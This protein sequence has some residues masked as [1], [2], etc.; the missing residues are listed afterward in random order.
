MVRSF[1]V[2][3]MALVAIS[4]EA[5]KAPVNERP[6]GEDI[7]IR[8]WDNA[9]APHSNNLTCEV[10]EPQPNRLTFNSTMELLV[11]V[12]D[13]EK[14]A[15]REQ[16]VVICPGGGYQMLSMDY[17]GAI[18]AQWFADNGITAAVLKYRMP[19]GVEQV[20]FEDAEK[21][22]DIMRERAAEWGYKADQ[23]GIVGSSAGGHLAAATSTLAPMA[24]RP[25]FTILFYPVITSEV[26]KGHQGSFNNLLGVERSSAESEFYS[27]DRRVSQ[28]TP[29]A[30]IF[31]SSNDNVVPSISSTRYFDALQRYNIPVSLYLFPTGGHGWGI[32]DRVPF[33]H[34][35]QELLLDW[36]DLYPNLPVANPQPQ[37]KSKK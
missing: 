9:T 5:K 29:P 4:A 36:L 12:A 26:G 34:I 27:L 19:N 31:H 1:L 21:A 22:I 2:V 3:A 28:T 24:S 32:S 8:V 25:N 7:Y 13:K 11:F 30:I 18:M 15:A 23:V 37:K 20:P 17:E 14:A 33:R 16:A 6:M 35:W 10:K